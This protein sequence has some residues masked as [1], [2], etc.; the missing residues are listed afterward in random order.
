MTGLQ[1]TSGQVTK[2]I[3]GGCMVAF[4]GFGFAAT[5]GVFL[6]PMS[7]ALGWGRE[8]FSLSVAVQTLCWGIAQPFAGMVADRY[9]TGRVLAFGAV[10]SA[11][12]FLM[13]ATLFEPALFIASGV[14]V[15]VGTGCCSFPIVIVALGKLM[16]AERRSYVLGLGTAAASLGMFVAAPV[17][18]WLIDLLGW[19]DAIWVIVALY[20]AILPFV[21]PIAR[22]SEPTAAGAGN[23]GFAYAVG[24]AFRDRSYVCLFIGFFVCGFHVSLIQTHLPA[25]AIDM[26]MGA[27]VGALA[28]SLIGLFNI[29]GSFASGWWG[30]HHSRRD[31]LA[32]IYFLRAVVIAGFLAVPLSTVS[33]YVFAALMGVLWLST[34][35]LTTGLIAHTQGLTFLSTLAGLV[36]F[37]HQVG[38]FIGA[39]L[40]GWFFDTYQDYGSVWWIAV[41]LGL[42][43]ALVHLPIR[44][45]PG[46]L[47]RGEA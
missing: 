34:V 3:V 18:V 28:L 40:G 29:G 19:K 45:S 2:A 6:L 11:A 15:G 43:A 46:V 9:G 42:F 33:V 31:G 26:G 8:I 7:E 37:S 16:P 27:V 36:F 21:V 12:G 17:S 38:G 24:K 13:R 4:L 35:P 32:A 1:P 14:L 47:A 5:F 41:A 23:Q 10:L 22:V 25:Y 30:Q 44:E 39:W 20:V